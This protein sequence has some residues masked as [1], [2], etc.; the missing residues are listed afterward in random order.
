MASYMV[1][2]FFHTLA[3]IL[4]KM[5][6]MLKI[7]MASTFFLQSDPK[8]TFLQNVMLVSQFER[9]DQKRHLS[10]PLFVW[11]RANNNITTRCPKPIRTY[12]IYKSS[13]HLRLKPKML[14]FFLKRG[15]E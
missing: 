10:A 8:G 5:A 1:K 12:L 14:S 2:R 3:A 6:A 15:V 9:F 11:P 13:I 4:E 7:H